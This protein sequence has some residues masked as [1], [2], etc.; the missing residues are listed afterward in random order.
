M[1]NVYE[2]LEFENVDGGVWKQGWDVRVD[3]GRFSAS[4][5]LQVFV[6]PHSH[7]DPGWIKTF[8]R[9]FEDQTKHILDN[10][11]RALSEDPTL[12]FIWAEI[13]YFDLWWRGIS[14]GEKAKLLRLV[15]N[16]QLEF[17]TG[18]WVMPDEAA[19]HYYGILTQLREG[20]QWLQKHL[21]YVPK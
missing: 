15:K 12:R 7:N 3:E 13:S 19:S 17:V 8:Q 5:K 20:H 14:E 18:G 1:L 6:I 9:Y 10:M 21:G 2:L 4:N 11:L 16:G